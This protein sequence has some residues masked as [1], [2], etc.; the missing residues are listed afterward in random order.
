MKSILTFLLLIFC[1]NIQAQSDAALRHENMVFYISY[2]K[3]YI[4][5]MKDNTDSTKVLSLLDQMNILAE[6]ISGELDKVVIEQDTLAMSE[7]TYDYN[8]D[9]TDPWAMPENDPNTENEDYD[10]DS[11]GMGKYM[12]FKKKMKS[13]IEIQFGINDWVQSKVTDGM[14][15]PD[16][17]AA[18]SWFWDFGINRKIRI[19]GNTSKVAFNYGFSYL[20]NRFKIDNDLRLFIN[21][22]KNV[23]FTEIQNIKSSPKLNVGYINM[24]LG[25]DFKISKGFNIGLGG[26]IGYRVHTVQKFFLKPPGETVEEQRY[27]NYGLNNWVYGAKVSLGLNNFNLIGRYNFSNFFKDNPNFEFNTFMIGTSFKLF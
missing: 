8:S 16:V 13:S 2:V 15:T 5:V 20:I 4:N 24:P 27:A 18:G 7:D 19:G 10:N 1:F 12:P 26:Y 25:F 6:Q 23:E 14:N 21:D 17:N 3:D 22:D 9:E 11:F